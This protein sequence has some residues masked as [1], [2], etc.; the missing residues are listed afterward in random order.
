MTTDIVSCNILITLTL[1]SWSRSPFTTDGIVSLRHSFLP[2][3]YPW[4]IS[5][6]ISFSQKLSKSSIF[7]VQESRI[8]L[9]VYF[10]IVGGFVI[11]NITPSPPKIVWKHEKCQIM[12]LFL[13]Q[14]GNSLFQKS[15]LHIR[16]LQKITS[17]GKKKFI[18][19]LNYASKIA[20]CFT[21]NHFTIHKHK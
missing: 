13:F 7:F 19:R 16:I 21:S 2:I 12:F 8:C 5:V 15:K 6:N 3:S 14:F 4:I 1:P 11:S 10:K 20:S 9:F 18:F 17:F